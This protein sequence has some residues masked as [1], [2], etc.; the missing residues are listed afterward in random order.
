ML[1]ERFVRQA[2]FHFK[3]LSSF[4]VEICSLVFIFFLTD[5]TVAHT[6]ELQRTVEVLPIGPGRHRTGHAFPD[7]V[8]R[9]T[10]VR[11]LAITL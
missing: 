4:D 7:D 2:R 11:G 3:L 5:Q 10:G 9:Q 1:P 8:V 6:R